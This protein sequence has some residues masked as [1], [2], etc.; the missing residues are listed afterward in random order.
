MYY[1]GPAL[2]IVLNY[3]VHI[4]FTKHLCSNFGEFILCDVLLNAVSEGVK[5]SSGVF[6][7]T[8]SFINYQSEC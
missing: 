6:L 1:I 3:N 7:V 8:E 5:I 2:N 4:L